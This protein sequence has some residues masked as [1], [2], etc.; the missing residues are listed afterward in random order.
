MKLDSFRT[1]ASSMGQLDF[2]SAGF[3]GMIFLLTRF[4]FVFKNNNNSS[5]NKV[6]KED[7]VT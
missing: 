5:S 7:W 6:P 2:R 3:G 4:L 1:A